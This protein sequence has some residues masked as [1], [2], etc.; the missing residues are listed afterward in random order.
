VLPRRL[1]PVPARRGELRHL[2][3]QGQRWRRRVLRP[4]R[5][6]RVRRPRP[7]APHFGRERADT[8]PGPAAAGRL[9][10]THT[11]VDAPTPA[12]RLSAGAAVALEPAVT[13]FLAA[14][15]YPPYSSELSPFEGRL[16]LE[17][18]QSGLVDKPD[19][20]IED[21]IVFDSEDEVETRI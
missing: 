21:I 3:C 6:G 12:P 10:R 2:R 20:E 8:D 7:F 1:V 19:V 11:P 16:V 9:A 13:A 4:R 5:R 17:D 15:G 18:L 14:A